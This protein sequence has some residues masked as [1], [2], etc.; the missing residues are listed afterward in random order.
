MADFS[1]PFGS[2]GEHRLPTATE[3]EQGFPCGPADRS[4]FNGL[5][6]RIEAEI[7]EVISHAGIVQTDDRDTLLREAIEALIAAATGGGTADDYILM[8]QARSRL[9][10]FPDVLTEDGKIPVTSPSNGTVRVPGWVTF[11]HRGI[12]RVTTTQTDFSTV[13]NRTYHLRWSPADG[14]VLRDLASGA[15]NPT[16]A[17]ETNA[18]FDSTYDDMLVARVITNSSNV[19]TITNLVNRHSLLYME[20]TP[21]VD[22]HQNSSQNNALF[23][24]SWTYNFARTPK[25]LLSS[26]GQRFQQQPANVSID[27]DF[28]LEDPVVTRYG[29][30]VTD[31]HNDF[32]F[33]WRLGLMAAA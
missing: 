4:L 18:A 20:A 9:P 1:P 31:A 3:K 15:Y 5:F 14:F 12:Y 30:K 11:Q 33:Q 13:A 29:T 27:R 17:A 7:G 24:F 26:Y 32:M 28:D 6:R 25:V 16:S 2:N 8:T 22:A 10:F 19:A 23:N 21:L